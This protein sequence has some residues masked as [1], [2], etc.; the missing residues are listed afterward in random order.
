MT[1]RVVHRAVPAAMLGHQ[2]QIHQ[3]TDRPIGAQHR[4]GQLEQRI[5]PRGQR[6]VE[7]LPETG[8]ITS[9]GRGVTPPRRPGMRNTE[10]RGH[11]FRLRAL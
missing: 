8:K 6:R 11:R 3:R 7:L 2:R 5:R 9:S 10:H 4:I 1:Q